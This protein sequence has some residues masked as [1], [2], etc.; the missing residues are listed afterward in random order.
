MGFCRG[1]NRSVLLLLLVAGTRV[2]SE[3]GAEKL[4][5]TDG[6]VTETGTG[7]ASSS[8]PAPTQPTSPQAFPPTPGLGSGSGVESGPS[9]LAGHPAW[10]GEC[11]AGENEVWA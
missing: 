7:G 3:E 4:R 9:R 2:Q 5:R 6:S 10:D 1:A 8:I 11:L